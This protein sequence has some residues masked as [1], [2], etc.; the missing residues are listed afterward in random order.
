M[1][2]LG[3][4]LLLLPCFTPVSA[5]SLTHSVLRLSPIAVQLPD[6][7]ASLQCDKPS[8]HKVKCERAGLFPAL[9]ELFSLGLALDEIGG[10]LASNM[11]VAARKQKENARNI[12]A[13][14]ALTICKL[15]LLQKQLRIKQ[16]VSRLAYP[17]RLAARLA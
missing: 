7:W 10:A 9:P 5:Q 13:T 3:L 15:L 1:I 17:A 16:I 14:K 8:A 11:C 6:C 2:T 4:V 12:C